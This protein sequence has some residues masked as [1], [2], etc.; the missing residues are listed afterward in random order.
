MRS[1]E[2]ISEETLKSDSLLVHDRHCQCCRET[3]GRRRGGRMNEICTAFEEESKQFTK[4]SH[5]YKL[6]LKTTSDV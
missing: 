1:F 6:F 2:N 5:C 3:E 4:T